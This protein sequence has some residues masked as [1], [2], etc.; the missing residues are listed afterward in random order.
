[1]TLFMNN[2][3]RASRLSA[4]LCGGRQSQYRLSKRILPAGGAVQRVEQ[5]PFLRSGGMTAYL[6]L[7]GRQRA[8][9]KE[10][11]NMAPEKKRRRTPSF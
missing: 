3:G 4:F 7:L 2:S 10:K 11:A 9:K 8:G 6:R 1:M 5:Q